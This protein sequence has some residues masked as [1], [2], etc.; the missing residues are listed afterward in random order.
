MFYRC[1]ARKRQL[2]WFLPLDGDMPHGKGPFLKN[3]VAR[4][5][6]AQIRVFI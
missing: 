1:N 3:S 2:G 4:M 6:P 5:L